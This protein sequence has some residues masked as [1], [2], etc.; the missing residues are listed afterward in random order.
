MG[1]DYELILE[2]DLPLEK[3]AALVVSETDGMSQLPGSPRVLTAD[4][5]ERLG[6]SVSIFPGRDGYYDAEADDGVQW[7]WEPEAYIDVTFH[8]TKNDLSDRGTLNM[9]AAVARV[10]DGRPE[11]AA[12]TL[13]GNWLLLTRMDGAIRK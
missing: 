5:N 1:I 10:L 11:N 7:E 4:L 3:I 8:M 13:D 2:A 6:Y 9:V 12:L